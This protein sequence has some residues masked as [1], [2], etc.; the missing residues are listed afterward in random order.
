MSKKEYNDNIDNKRQYLIEYYDKKIE[1]VENMGY[2]QFTLGYLNKEKNSNIKDL[3][4]SNLKSNFTFSD[5]STNIS[6][7]TENKI[8]GTENDEMDIKKMLDKKME[9]Y[10]RN[11]IKRYIED[12]IEINNYFPYEKKN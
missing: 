4:S 6:E 9:I 7:K 12:E 1:S 2:E 10:K 3:M 8:E 11:Q 5:L